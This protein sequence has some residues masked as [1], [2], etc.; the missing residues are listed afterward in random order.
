[1]SNI[2]GLQDFRQE[3]PPGDTGVYQATP[4]VIVYPFTFSGIT[5]IVAQRMGARGWV[6]VDYGTVAA[7][8]IQAGIDSLPDEGGLIFFK[9]HDYDLGIVTLT[10]QRNGVNF[11]G[12]AQRIVT[13]SYSGNGSAV[14]VDAGGANLCRKFTIRQVYFIQTGAAQTGTA[15]TLNRCTDFTVEDIQVQDFELGVVVDGTGNFSERGNIRRTIFSDVV[16]PI[17][18]TGAG[19]QGVWM[20]LIEAPTCSATVIRAGSIGIDLDVTSA[21]TVIGSGGTLNTVET[22]IRVNCEKT[23]IVSP[24]VE[25]STTGI[26]ITSEAINTLIVGTS[27]FAGTATPISNE[28]MRTEILDTAI[29]AD[30]ID[31]FMFG[32]PEHGEVGELGWGFDT[33]GTG[34]LGPTVVATHPGIIYL[35]TGATAASRETLRPD[36]VS[37]ILPSEKWHLIF[38]IRT[39]EITDLTIRLGLS[40]DRANPATE[41][42]M[43][44]FFDPAVSTNWL[45]KNGDGVNETSTPTGIVVAGTTWYKLDIIN[46]ITNIKFYVNDVLKATNTTNLPANPLTPFVTIINNADADKWIYI[47]YFRMRLGGLLR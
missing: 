11:V 35:K 38:I 41:N 24:S 31:D 33:V 25:S 16:V 40:T 17:R 10:V 29:N 20:L 44:F 34:S 12:E 1:M 30:F 19:V 23:T 7:T 3:G 36:A 37:A 6:L 42:G 27:N 22:G 14:I 28:G 39:V 18:L 26:S 13:F 32:S 46:C 2:A 4:S 5:Y 9:G 15:L 8:V 21:V 47:D 43:V 45:A